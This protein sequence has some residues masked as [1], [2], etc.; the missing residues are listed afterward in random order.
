MEEKC[1]KLWQNSICS[2][3]SLESRFGLAKLKAQNH[4]NY[5][6]IYKDIIEFHGFKDYDAMRKHYGKI[7]MRLYWNGMVQEY[8]IDQGIK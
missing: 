3:T 8:L 2:V 4:K 5:K 1:Y 6:D 7:R